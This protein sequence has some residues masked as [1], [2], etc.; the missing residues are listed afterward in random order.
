MEAAQNGHGGAYR[1][2]LRETS[3]WL[4]RC[5]GGRTVRRDRHRR[6]RGGGGQQLDSGQLARPAQSQAILL[7]KVQS[8]S[9]DEASAQTGLSPSAVKVSIHRG[10]VPA[11]H[12]RAALE[13][14][15]RNER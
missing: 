10:P 8:Y 2:R 7:V 11:H 3:E 9:V 14:L 15:W 13:I 6:S 12:R 5:F 1:R 4:K